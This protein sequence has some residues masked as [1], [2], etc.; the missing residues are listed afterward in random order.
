M[1][2]LRME[3]PPIPLDVTGPLPFLTNQ[4]IGELM[5][6]EDIL[7]AMGENTGIPKPA[8]PLREM[9]SL[10]LFPT[11]SDAPACCQTVEQLIVLENDSLALEDLER[12]ENS[13]HHPCNPP[14]P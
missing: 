5:E 2:T 7:K 12:S 13:I 14:C 10:P 1:N 4:Q 3:K 11:A 9:V 6:V 8:E